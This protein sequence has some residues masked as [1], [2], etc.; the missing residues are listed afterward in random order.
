MLNVRAQIQSVTQIDV[1]TSGPFTVWAEKCFAYSI[2][3]KQVEEK[4]ESPRVGVNESLQVCGDALTA[5]IIQ[6][7]MNMSGSRLINSN[8]LWSLLTQ[9]NQYRIRFF[10]AFPVQ[11]MTGFGSLFSFFFLL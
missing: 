11:E 4:M 3:I 8:G 9:Y 10:S 2:T 5:Q 6:N 1:I 7:M